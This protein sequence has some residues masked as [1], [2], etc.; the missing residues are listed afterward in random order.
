MFKKIE[1]KRIFEV[2]ASQ[3][4]DAILEG[5]LKPGDRLLPEMELAESFGV[6]R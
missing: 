6:G 5:T 4:R 2:I 3:V 1:H